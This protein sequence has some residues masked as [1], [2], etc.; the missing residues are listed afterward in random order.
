MNDDADSI[1]IFSA[2]ASGP[3]IKRPNRFIV[4]VNLPEGEARAHCPNPGRLI[5]LMNPGRTMILEKSRDPGRKTAWT[6]AAAEY[7]GLTVPL[8]SAKANAVTG[9]LI[10]P[11]LF[12][13]ARDIKAEYSYGRSRF[14]WHF[15]SGDKEIFLEV[16]ACTLIE[17]GTA[18]FPDAPSL[19]ASRHLEELAELAES[20]KSI[21]AHAVFVIMNPGTRRFIPNMHTDPD[22]ALTMEKVQ[23]RVSF[24]AVS[25]NCSSDGILNLVRMDI[26]VLADKTEAVHRDSG[27]YMILSKLDHCRIEIGA[28]GEIDFDGGWYVYTGSA[29][30]GLGSRVRRHLAKRKKKHWHMDYLSSAASHMKGFPIYTT[31]DLECSLAADLKRIADNRIQGFGCSDCSC[32]SHLFYFRQNPLQNRAFL[33]LLFHY[34]HSIVFDS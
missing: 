12:P 26:P 21:E 4:H 15:Y 5:E 22:F 11:R 8:F 25:T 24:H 2:D 30:K 23:D 31:R 10:I 13:D 1:R 32:D 14:D 28:L 7:N 9:K 18:M 6:L 19:R 3:L 33:D 34:R 27:I 17:E 20:D 29:L 16:K